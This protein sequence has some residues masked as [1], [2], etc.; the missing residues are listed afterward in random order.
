MIRKNFIHIR[1][2]EKFP[3]LNHTFNIKR[4]EGNRSQKISSFR[5]ADILRSSRISSGGNCRRFPFFRNAQGDQETE[6]PDD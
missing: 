1:K 3:Q 6:T 2:R 4:S 5:G